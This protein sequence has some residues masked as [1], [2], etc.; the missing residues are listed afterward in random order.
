MSMA[1][2]TM[3]LPAA[4]TLTGLVGTKQANSAMNKAYDKAGQ[5]IGNVR[6][7]DQGEKA[8][9]DVTGYLANTYGAGGP[10]NAYTKYGAVNPKYGGVLAPVG[11]KSFRV[12][13][14]V[15]ANASDFDVEGKMKDYELGAGY[16]DL[17]TNAVVGHQGARLGVKDWKSGQFQDLLSSAPQGNGVADYL[18][19]AVGGFVKTLGAMKEANGGTFEGMFKKK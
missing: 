2:A 10:A 17:A 5:I 14:A 15:A 12:N 16:Q 18:V 19:P 9:K 4:G 7:Y 11:G 6:T 13:P 1:G 3:G 8:L